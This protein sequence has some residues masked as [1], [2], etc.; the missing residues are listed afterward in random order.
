MTG[1]IFGLLFGVFLSLWTA[2]VCGVSDETVA[3]ITIN[4]TLLGVGA[5]YVYYW[6]KD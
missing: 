6:A 2:I 5:E 3:L 4:C 1:G